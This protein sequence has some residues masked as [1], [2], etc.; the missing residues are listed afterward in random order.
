MSK[1]LYD[2]LRLT[3]LIAFSTLKR[4]DLG[5]GSCIELDRILSAGKE[6]K[7]TNI[8]FYVCL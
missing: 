6:L 8:Q 3:F 7:V 1:L 2:Y 5:M 4:T